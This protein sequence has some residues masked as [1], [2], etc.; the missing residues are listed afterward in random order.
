[1][2]Q[3]CNCVVQIH[4]LQKFAKYC[5]LSRH[6]SL[7]FFIFSAISL[8]LFQFLQN[9]GEDRLKFCWTIIDWKCLLITN[10]LWYEPVKSQKHRQST[11]LALS[12]CYTEPSWP[13]FITIWKRRKW[14]WE[15]LKHLDNH[16]LNHLTA[17]A[18]FLVLYIATGEDLF[19]R[20]VTGDEKWVHHFSDP[21]PPPARKT[22]HEDLFF[23][24]QHSG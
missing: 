3:Y 19:D 10:L 6:A 15:G 13:S 17:T 18:Q 20:I 23:V 1:M 21:P 5:L 24:Q 11:Y 22:V 2:K 16:K 12:T 8:S 7:C 9:T 4:N 14:A